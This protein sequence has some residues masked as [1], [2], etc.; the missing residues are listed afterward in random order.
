MVRDGK[1]DEAD[2]ELQPA[3]PCKWG[4]DNKSDY[5]DNLLNANK[6][7][8]ANNGAGDGAIDEARVRPVLWPLCMKRGCLIRV[9]LVAATITAFSGDLRLFTS[10]HAKGKHGLACTRQERMKREMSTS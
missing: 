2:H 8:D 1:L 6:E 4:D 5:E 3:G 9:H 10:M 7:N